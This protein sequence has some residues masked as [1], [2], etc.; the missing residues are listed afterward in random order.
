M[1][2]FPFDKL[3]QT[4]LTRTISRE[5]PNQ[6]L[7]KM[8]PGRI[9]DEICIYKIRPERRLFRTKLVKSYLMPVIAAEAVLQ[10]I[11]LTGPD[12]LMTLGQFAIESHEREEDIRQNNSEK[13][14]EAERYFV[15]R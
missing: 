10:G 2:D 15:T 14:A 9:S 1:P 13:Q 8:I 6:Y 4:S 12:Y 3:P 7:V 11:D 5:F